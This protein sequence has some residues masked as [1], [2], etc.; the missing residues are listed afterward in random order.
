MRELRGDRVTNQQ[1]NGSHEY[2]ERKRSH[3]GRIGEW[4]LHGAIWPGLETDV[5]SSS[6]PDAERLPMDRHL[7]SR[8]DVGLLSHLN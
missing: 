8:S 2:S 5:A 4:L 6:R 1:P 7:N 3:V